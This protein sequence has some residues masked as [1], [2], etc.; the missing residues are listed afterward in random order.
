MR[1]AIPLLLVLGILLG[2]VY[3]A[4]CLFLTGEEAKKVKMT[5][6]AARWTTANGS[7]LRFSNGLAY[8]PVPLELT[9]AMNRVTL[10]LNFTLDE[11]ADTQQR[12]ELKYQASLVELDHTVVERPLHVEARAS[13]T[14]TVD[15]GPLQILYPAEY[16]FLLVEVGDFDAVPQVELVVLENVE[17]PARSIIWTGMGLLIVALIFSLRDAMRAAAKRGRL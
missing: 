11:I 4:Y 8:K 13:K 2:P 5:E 1:P 7:I 14:Q 6:R 15:V 17:T 10:R 9:P 16:L 12:R 3:Y